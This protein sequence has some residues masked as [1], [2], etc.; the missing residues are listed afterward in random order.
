MTFCAFA[1]GGLENKA[2][3]HHVVNTAAAAHVVINLGDEA[4]PFV[5]S[6]RAAIVRLFFYISCSVDLNKQKVKGGSQMG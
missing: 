6:Q 1:R 3:S 5:T 2:C 4:G